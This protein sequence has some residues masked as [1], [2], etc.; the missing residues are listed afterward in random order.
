[1]NKIKFTLLLLFC[2]AMTFAQ[3]SYENDVLPIF[4]VKC[5]NCH[6]IGGGGLNVGLDITSEKQF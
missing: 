6:G 3:T 1:M 5:A 2:L 4:E